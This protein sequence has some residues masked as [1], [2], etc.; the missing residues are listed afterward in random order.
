MKFIVGSAAERKIT[1][2][3]W[4]RPNRGFMTEMVEPVWWPKPAGAEN[5]T[6]AV[7]I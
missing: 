6:A 5:G 1:I 2:A 3:C 7:T 4:L